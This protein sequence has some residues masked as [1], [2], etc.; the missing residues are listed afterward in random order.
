MRSLLG[1]PSFVKLVQ[2]QPLG[3]V[4]QTVPVELEV[5]KF[6][7]KIFHFREMHE[8][9]YISI[10]FMVSNAAT[11]DSFVYNSISSLE[12]NLTAPAQ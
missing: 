7:V 8:L 4:R 10:S 11:F 6:S 2:V 1:Q 3:W 5:S 12:T 9:C